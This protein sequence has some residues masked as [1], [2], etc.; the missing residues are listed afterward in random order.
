LKSLNFKVRAH[1]ETEGVE[2]V[3]SKIPYRDW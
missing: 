1:G 3:P 2:I